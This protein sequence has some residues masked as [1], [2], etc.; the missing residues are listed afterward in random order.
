MAEWLAEHAYEAFRKHR[1]AL[2]GGGDINEATT[3]LRV[4]NTI[5][6]DVLRWDTLD[7]DAE[8]YARAEGYAD[9]YIKRG[10]AV[11]EAKREGKF[12]VLPNKSFSKEPVPFALL[13][14]ESKDA[15]DAL[16]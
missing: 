12:F 9:Y 15:A 2:E 7:V 5:L 4:I 14:S 6:F 11:I 3:R 8:K 13:A 1:P 16:S 10:S